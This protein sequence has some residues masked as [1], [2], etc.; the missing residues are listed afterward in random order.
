MNSNI[1]IKVENLNKRYKLK[2]SMITHETFETKELLAL[3]NVSFEIKKGES[4]GIIGTN[5]S[6]KSTLLKILAGVTKPTSGTVTINGKVASILDIGAGFHPE[7]SGKEN[8]FLNGHLLGFSRKEIKSKYDEIVTFSGIEKFICEPIK[9]YSSG[10]YLRLAFSIMS[11]LEFDIYLFDEVMSVGDTEFNIKLNA[12]IAELKAK[13]N[14][15]I[16]VTHNLSEIEGQDSYL[17]MEKGILKEKTKAK[18]LLSRYLEDAFSAN[19]IKVYSNN[20]TITDFS[21]YKSSNGLKITQFSLIQ[22]GTKKFKT[23]SPFEVELEIENKYISDS[24]DPILIIS[25]INGNNILSSCPLLSGLENKISAQTILRYTCLIP[26]KFLGSQV[27]KI[28]ICIMKNLNYINSGI[29]TIGQKDDIGI[30]EIILFW[31]NIIVFKPVYENNNLN[32]DFSNF[33][34]HGSLLPDFKWTQKIS[35]GIN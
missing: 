35:R 24:L 22:K 21:K 28:S 6:G 10:M 4:V 2:N 17:L 27:Y 5:G 15:I 12:K 34:I 30:P 31:E 29:T 3:N 8:I 14:T 20:I 9:N 26:E 25:D 33:N 19:D 11:H 32:F 16:H 13:K 18:S 23:N 7:L 1:A